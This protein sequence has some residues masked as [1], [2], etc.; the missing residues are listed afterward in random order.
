[1][2]THNAHDDRPRGKHLPHT[3]DD[4]RVVHDARFSHH[5]QETGQDILWSGVGK[6]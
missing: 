5:E 6:G 4:I 1:M 2:D 3:Q